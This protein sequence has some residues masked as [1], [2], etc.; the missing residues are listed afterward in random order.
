M[1]AAAFPVEA[2]ALRMHAWRPLLWLVPLV[3]AWFALT[4]AV[5]AIGASGIP[6]TAPRL[7]I[8]IVIALGLWLGLEGTELTPR[9]RR[10]VW[11]A[12]ML[13]YTLWLAV[14][15][16]A[17]INGAFLPGHFPP[18]LPL[19]IFLP[20][21]IGVPIVL[22]SKRIGEVL[23]AMPN[24][25][26]VGLQVYRVLGGVFLIAWART[27]IPGVFAL[28]AGIGDMMTG[29]LALPTAYLVAAGGAEGRRAAFAWN[30]LGLTDFA[31][32]ITLGLITS[33]GPLQVI[34]P[35]IG[36]SLTGTYP[37]VL[38]PAF[39][40]PSSILLHVLSLRQLRRAAKAAARQATA[41]G[42]QPT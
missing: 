28:P 8:Q 4:Y 41:A 23:D 16:S 7:I 6:N 3:A 18:R 1:T 17:A 14:I 5:P 42:S 24:Q 33:P 38:I 15:W 35:S 29:L 9:Q 36:N 22:Q 27:L 11:L 31:V 37:T 2:I 20:V 34:V 25:W 26:L 40:V 39:A 19:A 12:V 21:V 13:P 32:A 10:N 30:I